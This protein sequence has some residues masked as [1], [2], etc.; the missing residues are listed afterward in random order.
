MVRLYDVTAKQTVLCRMAARQELAACCLR[1][2]RVHSEEVGW[3]VVWEA[4]I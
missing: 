3:G 4:E 1:A 2:W